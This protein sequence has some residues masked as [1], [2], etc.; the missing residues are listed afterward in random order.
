MGRMGDAA[1]RDR[2][3]QAA[4]PARRGGRPLAAC[5]GPPEDVEKVLIRLELQPADVRFCVGWWPVLWSWACGWGLGGRT[6]GYG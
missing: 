4:C 1:R 5:S 6:L 3:G 2:A